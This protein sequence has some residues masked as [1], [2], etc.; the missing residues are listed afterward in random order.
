MSKPDDGKP[1]IPPELLAR[2]QAKRSESTPPAQP[3]DRPAAQPSKPTR[4]P[5]RS[6]TSVPVS[7]MVGILLVPLSAAASMFLVAPRVEESKAQAATAETSIVEEQ[8]TTLETDLTSACG[9]DGLQLVELERSGQISLVQQAALDAL[10]PICDS[11][12][13]ALPAPAA[14]DRTAETVIIT[15]SNQ[16]PPAP[17]AS[18]SD[19]HDD[20]H[21]DDD[22]YDDDHDD[23]DHEDDD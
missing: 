13:M 22:H 19:D 14:P 23:D 10:R 20:D 8:A 4:P 17:S 21:D 16:P 5:G 18:V 2:S 9:P 15:A 11:N 7:V 3:V 12:G 1:R 6:K